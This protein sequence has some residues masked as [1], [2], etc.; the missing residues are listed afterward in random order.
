MKKLNT[1]KRGT[2]LVR[3][4]IYV[5]SETQ[6]AGLTLVGPAP[7]EIGGGRA[8]CQM[9]RPGS[10]ETFLV[11][12]ELLI[13]DKKNAGDADIDL[14]DLPTSV[15]EHQKAFMKTHGASMIKALYVAKT[16]NLLVPAFS[17]LMDAY[18]L[19][20]ATVAMLI[21]TGL[22]VNDPQLVKSVITEV[23]GVVLKRGGPDSTTVV[24]MEEIFTWVLE[25]I[26]LAAPEMEGL[27]AALAQAK[28]KFTKEN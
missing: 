8:Y 2:P 27:E 1:N 16:E 3:G 17:V 10:E 18:W 25:S 21:K 11:D 19:G 7:L 6:E 23:T 22:S 28:A 12:E 15:A 24:P 5:N 14:E 9:K 20:A 13:L 26:Q 4:L